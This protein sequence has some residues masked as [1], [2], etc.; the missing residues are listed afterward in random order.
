MAGLIEAFDNGQV[1]GLAHRTTLRDFLARRLNCDP[2]RITR[3]LK[4]KRNMNDKTAS[5]RWW[6]L[7]SFQSIDASTTTAAVDESTTPQLAQTSVAAAPGGAAG[8]LAAERSGAVSDEERAFVERLIESFKGGLLQIP[9]GTSLRGFLAASLHCKEVRVTKQFLGESRG[10]SRTPILYARSTAAAAAFAAEKRALDGLYEAFVAAEAQ[11]SERRAAKKRSKPAKRARVDAPT[12][13]SPKRARV[14]KSA[15]AEA[16]GQAAQ[17]PPSVRVEPT[18]AEV[19]ATTRRLA[20]LEAAFLEG[21]R[22]MPGARCATG[23]GIFRVPVQLLPVAPGWACEPSDGATPP[24]LQKAPTLAACLADSGLTALAAMCLDELAVA[25]TPVP[26]VL[27]GAGSSSG[28]GG[29]LPSRGHAPSRA[30]WSG[31]G[32]FSDFSPV[33]ERVDFDND[34]RCTSAAATRIT[35]AAQA[36]WNERISVVDGRVT[37]RGVARR[38]RERGPAASQP[39]VDPARWPEAPTTTLVVSTAAQRLRDADHVSVDALTDRLSNVDINVSATPSEQPTPPL[40]SRLRLDDS[41]TLRFNSSDD[42]EAWTPAP[43]AV[44][45]FRP[46]ANFEATPRVDA[47]YPFSAAINADRPSSKR[48]KLSEDDDVGTARLKA[49]FVAYRDGDGS[50]RLPRATPFSV[51]RLDPRDD[52]K[53]CWLSGSRKERGKCNCGQKPLPGYVACGASFCDTFEPPYLKWD[54]PCDKLECGASLCPRTKRRFQDCVCGVG[55]CGSGL[56]RR[57]LNS[58]GGK[59]FLAGMP[60]ADIEA[61]LGYSAAQLRRYLINTY[62]G[63]PEAATRKWEAGELE[64]EHIEPC[65]KVFEEQGAFYVNGVFTNAARYV[66]RLWNL[67]L[68]DAAMN[69]RK[70]ANFPPSTAVALAARKALFEGL[71]LS[72]EEDFDTLVCR[73]RGHVDEGHSEIGDP[74]RYR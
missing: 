55:R 20:D 39:N 64:V 43:T 22:R 45:S 33:A 53:F 73:V 65:A 37:R 38:R 72:I 36:A 3:K 14:K 18:P 52:A 46:P 35:E 29:R 12:E 25:A 10:F 74:A 48:A 23:T 63:G 57:L 58:F 59:A 60:T 47:A 11:R 40:W 62:P 13:P 2:F 6:V 34:E 32:S 4:N 26:S 66:N 50:T 67:Q 8:V 68:M 27:C 21:E 70:G 28:S 54:C 24:H 42:P 30:P 17:T 1:E 71:D 7:T 51:S 49:S 15:G 61:F 56:A 44:F 69:V 16:S 41:P 31:G 5:Y 19:A 9:E